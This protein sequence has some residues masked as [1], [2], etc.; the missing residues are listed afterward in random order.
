MKLQDI[1]PE[2]SELALSTFSVT[3]PYA[4][5]AGCGLCLTILARNSIQKRQAKNKSKKLSNL[6]I[7]TI[8]GAIG[9]AVLFFPINNVVWV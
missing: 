8:N 4:K 2:L 6:S 5:V 7:A 9:M 1:V 3:S